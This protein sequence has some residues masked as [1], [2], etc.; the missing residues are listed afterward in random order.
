[1]LT[2][3]I[4]LLLGIIGFAIAAFA[5]EWMPI[6]VV[7]LTCLG[8]LL[9]FDLVTPEEAISGFS[10]TAVI[11]VL[12]MFILSEGLVASGVVTK[13]GYRI[14]DA[15][16]SSKWFA[17]SLLLLLVGVVSALMNNTAAVSV[18]IPVS[19]H[20]AKHFRFS[21][22]K[23][24][25]PLSYTAM[26]AGTCTLIG[27]STNLLVSS[28]AAERGAVPFT[29]F[30][31]FYLGG[32]LFAVGL[33]YNLLVA[34]R[35]L[36]P[37]A[38]SGSL[39][40]KYHL[41]DFLT[42]LR[43]PEG[44]RLIGRTVLDE[45]IRANFQVAVL[46]ILRGKEKI[47]SDLRHTP[48][49][50]DDLLLVRGSME[51]ILNLK[52][53][54]RLQLLTDIK[55]N[56]ADL[57]DENNVLAEVQLA[58]ASALVGSTLEE[59]DFRRQFGSFVLAIARTGEM[60]RDKLA[61]IRL[62]QWDTLLVFGP[63]ARIESL[64]R[65]PDVVPLGELDLHIR[66][67]SRWWIAALMIPLVIVLAALGV[68]SLLKASILGVVALLLTRQLSM[69]Q[70]YRAVDWTV[71]FLL[72]T[73]LPLGIAMEKTGLATLIGE[74]L[75]TLGA[76]ISPLALLAILYLGTTL[77][78]SIFSNNATAVLMVPVAFQ[79]ATALGVDPKPFLMAI[80]YAASAS[81]MT[82]VGYQT[83]AM[84]FG[85]GNYRFMDYVKFGGPLVVL[86]WLVATLMIPIIWPF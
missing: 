40:K 66:L 32:I 19:M 83:N 13:L 45:D 28:L 39:T 57:A 71:I 80:T 70:G 76:Q 27:T 30:E 10:N 59:V 5:F 73:T 33:A 67:A 14:T 22:S 29:V 16:G 11:I 12:M 44:S 68:M 84:V 48:M 61:L 49:R 38:E 42:E 4:I 35:L 52:E 3:E 60:I 25:L 31:F 50:V 7:A 64:Y 69:Q 23:I 36:P 85:P 37:R 72:A 21:P 55:L 74:S 8:A 43:V 86:F 54:Y 47:T 26:M 65:Q 1:M 15:T 9:A 56:D 18:F 17:M 46:E 51:D 79:A 53:R 2:L 58:P 75:A 63:R 77:L 82:P 41:W 78:T 6:D 20:L 24:L 81:F 34:V 62:K